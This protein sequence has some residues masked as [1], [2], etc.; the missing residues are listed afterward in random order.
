MDRLIEI[1]KKIAF[2]ST[3][4]NFLHGALIIR[5]G[6]I[7]SKAFN[8]ETLHAEYNSL[9][10]L[11]PNK[12]RGCEVISIR[13]TST[14]LLAMAKPCQACERFLRDNGIKTVYY[15][16]ADRQVARMAL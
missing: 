14:G 11:W 6:N 12:R 8:H 13:V 2:R 4:K 7:L 5:N 9:K 3:N 10:R 15:S 1:A 16:T